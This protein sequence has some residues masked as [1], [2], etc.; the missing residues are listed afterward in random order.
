MH[1][2]LKCSFNYF[3]FKKIYMNGWNDV[4]SWDFINDV[5]RIE[6]KPK[7]KKYSQKLLVGLIWCKKLKSSNGYYNMGTK[8]NWRENEYLLKYIS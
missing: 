2:G 6:Q 4:K 7:K 8:L 5:E 3:E 1:R